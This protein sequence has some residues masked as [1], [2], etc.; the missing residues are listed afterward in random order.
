LN[1]GSYLDE[2]MTVIR[3]AAEYKGPK[4]LT[5]LSELDC[6]LINHLNIDDFVLTSSHRGVK[7]TTNQ[8]TYYIWKVE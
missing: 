2:G 1:K 8:A 5:V 4:L 3:E 7:T 6:C